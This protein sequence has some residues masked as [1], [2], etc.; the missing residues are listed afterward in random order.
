MGKHT[1]NN[2]FIH[3]DSATIAAKKQADINLHSSVNFS[4]QKIITNQHYEHTDYRYRIVTAFF[5]IVLVPLMAGGLYVEYFSVYAFC[6]LPNQEIII[7]LMIIAVAVGTQFAFYRLLH[8]SFMMLLSSTFGITFNKNSL[9]YDGLN[10][11]KTVNYADILSLNNTTV[12]I[13]GKGLS[14]D[15]EMLE[16]SLLDKSTI[17]INSNFLL[18]EHMLQL[19]RDLISYTNLP[20][21][22]SAQ[23]FF[24]YK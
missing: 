8:G 6:F 23:N 15:I 5:V 19:R 2:R 7:T 21:H 14:V 11:S 20:L 16:L 24:W 1:H 4:E 22:S 17:R 10:R 12:T 18:P 13:S 3:R 9:D